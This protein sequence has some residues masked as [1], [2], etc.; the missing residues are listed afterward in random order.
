MLNF[1]CS[2]LFPWSH[3]CIWMLCLMKS[4]DARKRYKKYF[5]KGLLRK[6]QS[7]RWD[8][9]LWTVVLWERNGFFCAY[10]LTEQSAR[11]FDT[12]LAA[13][14]IGRRVDLEG[15]K[16]NLTTQ[17]GSWNPHPFASE[18]N[19]V[20]HSHAR[21]HH[22]IL[23]ELAE[24]RGPFMTIGKKHMFFSY[25]ENQ[26][27]LRFHSKRKGDSDRLLKSTRKNR[28]MAT[29]FLHPR[30]EDYEWKWT[31]KTVKTHGCVV[32]CFGW[33]L[34]GW[35]FKLHSFFNEAQRCF[36]QGWIR[37][38]LGEELRKANVLTNSFC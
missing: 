19:W 29:L 26:T 11:W 34:R 15:G 37:A 3:G 22:K 31:C 2:W 5:G 20:G 21:N 38:D 7:G 30:Q 23:L 6:W 28:T 36:A 17:D 32:F 25:F 10:A 13:A 27:F 9:L 18:K 33:C 14:M 1:D 16:K 12:S 24:K 4:L 35:D 8:F